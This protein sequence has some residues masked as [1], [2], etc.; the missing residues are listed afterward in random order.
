[1]NRQA[2]PL[3]VTRELVSDDR[4]MDVVE[5]LFGT[6]FPLQLGPVFYGITDR[7]AGDY[8]GGYWSFYTLSNGGFYMAP[9]EDRIFQCEMPEYVRR[10][11]LGRCLGNH[12]MSLCVQQSA[13]L[14]E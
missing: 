4:R 10:L 12:R 1:M 3:I 6:T 5:G 2:S 13:I 11:S 8:A 9:L 7:M 14:P